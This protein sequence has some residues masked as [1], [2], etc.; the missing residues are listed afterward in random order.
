MKLFDGGR[1]PNPRRVRIFLS[2]KGMTVPVEK[3]DLGQLQHKSAE[4]TALNPLQRVPVLLLDDGTVITES[5]AI[6]RYLE[7]LRPEP[8]MFGR[9]AVEVGLVEMWNRRVELNLYQA[10][11]AVFRHL[12]PSMKEME[13]QVPEWGEANRPRVFDFL[14]LLDRELKDRMFIAGDHYTIADITGLVAVDF[15]RPAKLI[16][17]EEFTNLRRWHTQVGERTSAT[18]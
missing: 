4:F 14:A 9:S 2:E 7:A 6:C 1:A 18:A 13:A 10:V 5:I 12:H 16:M 17:P 3:I 8:P 15:M 11:S